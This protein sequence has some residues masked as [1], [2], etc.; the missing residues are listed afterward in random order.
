[1]E[2]LSGE[3]SLHHTS[4]DD[5]E[6]VL[7]NTDDLGGLQSSGLD[8]GIEVVRIGAVKHRRVTVAIAVEEPVQED[9]LE[10][11]PVTEL[12]ARHIQ[13]TAESTTLPSLGSVCVVRSMPSNA[14]LPDRYRAVYC[15]M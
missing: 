14:L 12:G 2:L 13:M 9:E 3:G 15:P 11:V 4:V 7:G 5:L 6:A 10:L 1:M 8:R